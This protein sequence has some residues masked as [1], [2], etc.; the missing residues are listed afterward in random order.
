MYSNKDPMQILVDSADGLIK[1]RG[2]K[3]I[4]CTFA[5]ARREVLHSEEMKPILRYFRSN[6]PQG[7]FA[8][9][10][11]YEIRHG[12]KTRKEAFMRAAKRIPDDA[13]RC[14]LAMRVT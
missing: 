4:D 5:E 3:G 13:V 2:R 6:T 9:I 10:A 8:A 14:D 7:R 1:E 12:A 11:D